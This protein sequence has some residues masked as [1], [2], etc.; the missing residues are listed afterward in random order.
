MSRV[1]SNKY[2]MAQIGKRNRSYVRFVLW[3]AVSSLL[4]WTLHV[5][6]HWLDRFVSPG[7]TSYKIS[8]KL[9]KVRSCRYLVC[10]LEPSHFAERVKG[11]QSG[12]MIEVCVHGLAEKVECICFAPIC[13]W[14]YHYITVFRQT[15]W[16]T[17][18]LV[19]SS[20]FCSTILKSI[21]SSFV[22]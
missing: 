12:C 9:E 21:V 6:V 18:S 14:I 20:D 4:L 22:L 7:L 13:L 5:V 2:A 11:C 10:E 17:A 1:C 15:L 19:L 3:A 8:G 16:E